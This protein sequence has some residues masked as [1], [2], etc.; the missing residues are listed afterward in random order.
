MSFSA[1]TIL[2]R[3]CEIIPLFDSPHLTKGSRNNLLTKTLEYNHK[4]VPSR[5]FFNLFRFI[6]KSTPGLYHASWKYIEKAYRIDKNRTTGS[7]ITKLTDEHIYEKKIRKMRVFPAAQISSVTTSN[8]IKTL[9]DS[10]G[11]LFSILCF[12]L[13]FTSFLF[14]KI[15]YLFKFA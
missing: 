6:D 13:F 15:T 12:G 5:D 2:Y 14:L 3:D 10:P 11:N 4:P 7:R 1:D 9:I 8:L